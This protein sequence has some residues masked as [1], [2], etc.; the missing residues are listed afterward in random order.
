MCILI[1]E[2]AMFVLGLIGLIG[3]KLPLSKGK[4][5][6]GTRA[7]IAGLIILLPLPL[8]LGAGIVIGFLVAGGVL[9]PDISAYGWCI[10][11]L[12]VFGCLGGAYAYAQ[13]TKPPE[14]LPPAPPAEFP[15]VPPAP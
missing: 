4:T 9:P 6:E 1:L 13:A 5:L 15:A 8:A 12:I 14:S 10:E 11:L 3:G 7:R 2:I